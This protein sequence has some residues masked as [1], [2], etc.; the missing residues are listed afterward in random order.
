VPAVVAD[1]G[2]LNYLVLIG[3]EQLLPRVF[4]GVSIPNEVEEE[5]KHPETPTVVRRWIATPPRWLTASTS[6]ADRDPTLA[7]LDDGEQAAIA[8]AAHL[9]A[10]LILMDDRAGVA[11]ARALGFSVTGTL[12]LLD[13]AARRH[14]LDLPTALAALKRTSFRYRPEL[15]DALLAE[16]RR[17]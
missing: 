12:G 13:R 6:P 5:L 1:T 3:A 11:A 10:D 4:A 16:H 8:L 17:R 2:P 9:R 7:A 14:M 15:I